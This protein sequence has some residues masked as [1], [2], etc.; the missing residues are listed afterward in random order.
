MQHFIV[1]YG[2]LA[3]F[4]LMLA[5]SAC[6]PIPSEL[7]MLCGGAAAAGAVA[8]VHL[9][10]IA[11]IIA[12]TAGNVVGSYAAWIVGRYAGQAAWRKWGRRFRLR[13]E[14][15]NR[16]EIWFDKHGPASVFLGRLLP[17]IRTFISLPAG[18]AAMNP[19]RFGLYTTAG[20]IP[21]TA[22]L[23][24]AGYEI[25]GN[26]RSVA[27]GFHGPTYAIAAIV[28]LLIGGYLVV[29]LRRRRAAAE[30]VR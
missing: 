21:W 9:N 15:L 30:G 11:V 7:T 26:W 24:I 2:Y 28:L 22:G 12:G 5:E 6:I 17:V 23:A 1:T 19:A 14:D 25:G 3:V 10:L 29:F 18:V 20:C 4:A 8:G 16:A 27:D 13:E